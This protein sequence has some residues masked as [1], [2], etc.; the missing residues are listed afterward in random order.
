MRLYCCPRVSSTTQYQSHTKRSSC[1]GSGVNLAGLLACE[2]SLPAFG[3]LRFTPRPSA[4]FAR[5]SAAAR[6]AA[7]GSEGLLEVAPLEEPRT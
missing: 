5:A 2:A 4:A 3:L 7:R 1:L 6:A